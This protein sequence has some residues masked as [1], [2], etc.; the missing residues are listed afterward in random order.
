MRPVLEYD[1]R[2]NLATSLTNIPVPQAS[3][4]VP[5]GIVCRIH[6][7]L[8]FSVFHVCGERCDGLMFDV[9]SCFIKSGW[10]RVAALYCPPWAAPRICFQGSVSASFP[11]VWH[12]DVCDAMPHA[13]ARGRTGIGGITH[14]LALLFI[15]SQIKP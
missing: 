9:I 14:V 10:D 2:S 1:R 6:R 3:C 5:C 13:L 7:T 4:G 11:T 8:A 15:I 12:T